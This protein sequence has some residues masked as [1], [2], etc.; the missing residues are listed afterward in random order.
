[1]ALGTRY[2]GNQSLTSRARCN[3][4]ITQDADVDATHYNLEY[5][6]CELLFREAIFD[7]TVTKIT[8]SE[9]ATP[10]SRSYPL[11]CPSFFWRRRHEIVCRHLAVSRRGNLR[12][13]LHGRRLLGYPVALNQ[14]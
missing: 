1:M 9:E 14:P 2:A 12:A 5:L 8:E 10:V 11:T 13:R 3:W 7:L 6:Y 4:R